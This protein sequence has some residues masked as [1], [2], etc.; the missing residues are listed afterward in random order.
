VNASE[1]LQR[2]ANRAKHLD[3]LIEEEVDAARR[4]KMIQARSEVDQELRQLVVVPPEFLE[5]LRKHVADL[6]NKIPERLSYTG[7][8]MAN[9]FERQGR[10]FERERCGG[11]LLRILEDYGLDE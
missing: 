9:V 11:E 10:R 2:L 3:S 4:S 6:S 7:D 5:E 1:E 8:K